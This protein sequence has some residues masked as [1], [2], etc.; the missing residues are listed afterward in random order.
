MYDERI[1]DVMGRAAFDELFDF[2]EAFCEKAAECGHRSF[3]IMAGALDGLELETRELSHERTFGVGYG[4]CTFRVTGENSSRHSLEIW[5]MRQKISAESLKTAAI[6]PRIGILTELHR[7]TA[8]TS[9]FVLIK[10][11]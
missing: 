7:N 6:P 3:C 10:C 8:P 9:F 11:S 2:N 5:K 4:I 1:M